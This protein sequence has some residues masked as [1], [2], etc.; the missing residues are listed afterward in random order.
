MIIVSWTFSDNAEILPNLRVRSQ[1][2]EGVLQ[3]YE[4]YP[5]HGYK[6]WIPQLDEYEYSNEGEIVTDKDGDPVVLQHYYTDGGATEFPDYDFETNPDS[7]QAVL[8]DD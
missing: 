2:K 8:I 3:F 4:I 1:F 5:S 6:L 7:L